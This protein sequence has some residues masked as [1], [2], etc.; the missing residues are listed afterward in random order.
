MDTIENQTEYGGQR[1]VQFKEIL[2]EN[3]L[4]A[5]NGFVKILPSV[6]YNCWAHLGNQFPNVKSTVN[7]DKK[8]W[9]FFLFKFFKYINKIFK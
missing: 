3:D 5:K 9:C 6:N 7:L 1:C 4:W 8:S 2:S